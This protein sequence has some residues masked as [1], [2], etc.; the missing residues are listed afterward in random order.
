M[1]VPLKDRFL[2]RACGTRSRHRRT[3]QLPILDVCGRCDLAADIMRG[4]PE[5]KAKRR[6]DGAENEAAKPPKNE[7][8]DVIAE[9]CGRTFVGYLAHIGRI[10]GDLGERGHLITRL[11]A[12]IQNPF[13]GGG[14]SPP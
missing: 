13:G 6:H 12:N 3:I 10:G 2:E 9:T 11:D 8:E 4:L 7:D 1:R 5:E 14:L